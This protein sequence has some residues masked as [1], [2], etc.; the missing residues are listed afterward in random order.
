M[1]NEIFKVPSTLSR[2]RVVYTR[3]AGMLRIV[4]SA[5]QSCIVSGLILPALLLNQNPLV[6]FWVWT[7]LSAAILSLDVVRT[8]VVAWMDK[9]LAKINELE[10]HYE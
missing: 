8:F 3:A 2:C 4:R 7:M 10:K 5:E 6:I 1:L 9:L